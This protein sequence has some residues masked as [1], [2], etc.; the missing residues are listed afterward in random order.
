MPS[1]NVNDPA[2][3]SANA[4]FA[5]AFVGLDASGGERFLG[6]YGVFHEPAPPG[7]VEAWGAGTFVAPGSTS[8]SIA[9][10]DYIRVPFGG[11][12]VTQDLAWATWLISTNQPPVSPVPEPS[13]YA[14]MLA[15]LGAVGFIARRVK[16]CPAHSRPV[17]G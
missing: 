16:N 9:T 1:G 8:A 3:I 12:T 4:S 6:Y 15:G 11:S 5:R 14:L 7:V 10:T 13:T 2:R 17:R